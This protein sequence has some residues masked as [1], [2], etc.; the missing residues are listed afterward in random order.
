MGQIEMLSTDNT[1]ER[2]NWKL[3]GS[4]WA[5]PAITFF[6]MLLALTSALV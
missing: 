5:L 3:P 6:L 2:A 4:S 1:Q